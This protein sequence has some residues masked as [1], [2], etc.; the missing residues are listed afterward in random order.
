MKRIQLESNNVLHPITS[1]FGNTLPLTD[2]LGRLSPDA[3]R[4]IHAFTHFADDP[5]TAWAFVEVMDLMADQGDL[6]ENPKNHPRIFNWFEKTILESIR[7]MQIATMVGSVLLAGGVERKTISLRKA[8]YVVQQKIDA[9]PKLGGGKMPRDL[10]NIRDAFKRFNPSIHLLLA[11]LSLSKTDFEIFDKDEQSLRKFLSAA[12][13]LQ[14]IFAA[15]DLIHDWRPWVVSPALIVPG[16]AIEVDGL[17]EAALRFAEDY[18][19]SPDRI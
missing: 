9:S 18:K 12:V 2:A 5:A 8:F 13:Y 16:R 3:P 19:A 11:M 7:Q 14:G 4:I 15:R 17:S 6:D 10:S 1:P